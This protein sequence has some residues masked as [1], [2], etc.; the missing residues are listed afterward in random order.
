MSIGF[1]CNGTCTRSLNEGSP[2]LLKSLLDPIVL[3][4]SVRFEK[5]A[6]LFWEKHYFRMMAT[7][8]RMRFQI[9]NSYTSEKLILEAKKLINY[10]GASKEKAFLFRFHFVRERPKKTSFVIECETLNFLESIDYETTYEVDLYRENHLSSGL[11]ANQSIIN[12]PIRNIARTFAIENGLDDVLL[13]NDQKQLVEAT[14]GS[15]FFIQKNKVLTPSLL[16]GVQNSVFRQV[17]IDFVMQQQ[18]IEIVEKSINPFEIQTAQEIF[19]LDLA[20]G[21]KSV[22]NYRK[23]SFESLQTKKLFLDFLSSLAFNLN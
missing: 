22:R 13:L 16:S 19:I 18:N 17:F 7:L 11:L 23:T 14:K 3:E 20:S 6:F 4:E 2:S 12:V 1:N 5:E 9:P 8:R 21:I 15:L 10:L